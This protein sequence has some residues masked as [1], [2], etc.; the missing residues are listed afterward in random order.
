MPS[1]KSNEA[2]KT[3]N[4]EKL[5]R[6]FRLVGGNDLT[7]SSKTE[8]SLYKSFGRVN[9]PGFIAV[10]FGYS[11]TYQKETVWTQAPISKTRR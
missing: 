9:I 1:V 10:Y 5:N 4:D 3:R 11:G 8:P 2:E 6:T 7:P